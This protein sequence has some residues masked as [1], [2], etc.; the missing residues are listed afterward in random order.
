MLYNKAGTTLLL[1]PATKLS[2]PVIIAAGV[3]NIAAGALGSDEVTVYSESTR[4]GS[5]TAVPDTVTVA[6]YS[7]DDPYA[8]GEP[9]EGVYWHEVEGKPV[10]WEKQPEATE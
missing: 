8:D 3:T 4:W 10:I 2:A 7:A 6:Y 5:V 1:V 9:P